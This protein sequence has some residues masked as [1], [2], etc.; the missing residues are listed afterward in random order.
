VSSEDRNKLGLGMPSLISTVSQ[1]VGAA[2]V[3]QSFD[4][5]ILKMPNKIGRIVHGDRNQYTI[6]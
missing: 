2:Q 5:K 3:S 4:G 1:E 6:H